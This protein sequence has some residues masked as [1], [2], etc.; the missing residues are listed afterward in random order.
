MKDI[1][2]EKGKAMILNTIGNPLLTNC[3]LP[4]HEV[5]DKI[6]MHDIHCLCYE[7]IVILIHPVDDI[8]IMYYFLEDRDCLIPDLVT[9][10][11]MDLD[12]YQNLEG[13]V[14]ARM[15]NR[16]V[17]VL[18]RLQFHPYKEY[19]RKQIIAGTEEWCEPEHT[20]E[21]ADV[22]DLNDIYELLYGTFDVMTDHLVSEGELRNFLEM[23]QVLKVRMDG[24]LAGVLLF[25]V[26]GKKSY[27]RSICV[28]ENFV[29][30]KIGLSLLQG[31]FLRNRENTKLFYLWVESTNEKAIRLYER[32]GYKDDG[33]REYTYMY[34]G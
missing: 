5:M 21:T 28:S 2:T 33:L 25:E 23:S 3:Y 7:G 34:R 8:N 13:T 11:R 4:C 27:L 30:K 20:T 15:P 16:N 31:Y 17:D 6:A 1:L 29:G 24:E 10:I 19:I 9:K 26:F 12:H 14:V 18:E 22:S 32:L